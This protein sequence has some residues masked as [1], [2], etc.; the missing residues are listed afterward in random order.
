MIED[1]LKLI[2]YAIK[3]LNTK[4]RLDKEYFDRFI[5][6]IWDEFQKVHDDYKASFRNYID[7]MSQPQCN[8][9]AVLKAL[10]ADSVDTE[11]MRIRLEKLM[12]HLPPARSK[13]KGEHLKHLLEAIREYFFMHHAGRYTVTCGIKNIRF[14]GV[15][16]LS[17]AEHPELLKNTIAFFEEMLEAV[18][19]HYRRVAEAYYSLRKL[20]LA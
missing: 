10:L 8:V 5:E 2:E 12:D 18:Q 14:F 11:D 7:M 19:R 13:A 20:S 17:R 16:A 15:I 3:G 9:D 1:I 4:S 6:P